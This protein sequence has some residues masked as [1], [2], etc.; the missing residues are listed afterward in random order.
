[1]AGPGTTEPLVTPLVSP[2]EATVVPDPPTKLSG[3]EMLPDVESLRSWQLEKSAFG[4]G[5]KVAPGALP[6]APEAVS[7]PLAGKSAAPEATPKTAPEEA[8]NGLP[9]TE[10]RFVV[11]PSEHA[12]RA[13]E[14]MIAS[15]SARPSLMRT[16]RKS[17]GLEPV[18]VRSVR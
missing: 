13:T 11:D 6:T 15:A 4:C 1:M 5:P 8:P 2:L 10:T 3:G 14:L 7:V 12:V 16:D 9:A 17:E 18:A